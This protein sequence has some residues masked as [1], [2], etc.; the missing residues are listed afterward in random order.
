MLEAHE[1]QIVLADVFK[2]VTIEHSRAEVRLVESGLNGGLQFTSI[3]RE[4]VLT[5]H[6]STVNLV[7]WIDMGHYKRKGFLLGKA[8][9][10]LLNPF[11][12]T[13]VAFSYFVAEFTD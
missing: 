11:V 7:P 1:S 6:G 13:M 4:D 5:L 3:E 8:E 9:N 12:R 2:D 10:V